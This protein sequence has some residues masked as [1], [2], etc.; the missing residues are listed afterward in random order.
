M[1]DYVNAS[2]QQRHRV[3][4]DDP[5]TLLVK[6]RALLDVG[7]AGVGAWTLGAVHRAESGDSAAAAKAMWGA[8]ASALGSAK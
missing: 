1:F 7:V 6:Y 8:V 5:Q 4:F 3:I 2:T